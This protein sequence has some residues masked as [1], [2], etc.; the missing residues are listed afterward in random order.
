ME[1]KGARMRQVTEVQGGGGSTGWGEGTLSTWSRFV[2]YH[3]QSNLC[4][5]FVV[6]VMSAISLLSLPAM[7][8][9]TGPD[10]SS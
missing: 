1:G 9:V 5:C 8:G 3:T 4:F 2:L 7:R 6:S 10:Y